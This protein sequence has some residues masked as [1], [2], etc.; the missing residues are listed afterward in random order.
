MLKPSHTNPISAT[1][2]GLYQRIAGKRSAGNRIPGVRALR[3]LG[4]AEESALGATPAEP[5]FAELTT[6]MRCALRAQGG[7]TSDTP[8]MADLP[9]FSGRCLV[10]G[11]TSG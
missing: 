5:E 4:L 1:L 7:V 2:A 8:E 9:G 3:R 10:T 11:A 6:R